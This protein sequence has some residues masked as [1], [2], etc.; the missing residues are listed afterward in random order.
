M[1]VKLWI[2]R[3]EHK[4]VK[5]IY[6]KTLYIVFYNLILLL[7]TYQ[8]YLTHSKKLSTEFSKG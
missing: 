2:N 4:I 3:V 6:S 8:D 7:K 5:N 1:G